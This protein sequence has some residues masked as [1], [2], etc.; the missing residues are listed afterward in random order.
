MIKI[1]KF[2]DKTKQLKVK[3]PERKLQLVW[4]MSRYKKV[5]EVV[6]AII[7]LVNNQHSCLVELLGHH[8]STEIHVEH[9]YSAWIYWFDR[10][11]NMYDPINKLYHLIVSFQMETGNVTDRSNNISF[12]TG[13]QNVMDGCGTDQK[14]IR[15]NRN[16]VLMWNLQHIF[17]WRQNIGRFSNLH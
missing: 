9:F 17:I 4:D 1:W 10:K 5:D 8:Q 11:V 2:F 13:L 3:T 6:S 15:C 12:S 7:S 14:A 16:I